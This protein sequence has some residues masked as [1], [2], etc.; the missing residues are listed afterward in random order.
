MQLLKAEVVAHDLIFPALL[1][2]PV[3]KH[4]SQ[5]TLDFFCICNCT[6]GHCNLCMKNTLLA[7]DS[8]VESRAAFL[9]R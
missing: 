6:F 8:F 4:A 9:Q 7:Q 1:Q 5:N 3:T 2:Q